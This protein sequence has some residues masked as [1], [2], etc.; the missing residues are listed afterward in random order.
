MKAALVSHRTSPR[1]ALA[2]AV[3]ERFTYTTAAAVLTIAGLAVLAV[4]AG[5]GVWII[6]AGVLIAF[7]A[8]VVM[9]RGPFGSAIAE[10]R[11]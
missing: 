11:R 9:R 10:K 1:V 8:I 2:A 7:I 3:T 6:A 5:V 4:R